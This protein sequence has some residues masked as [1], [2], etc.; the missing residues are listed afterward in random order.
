MVTAPSRVGRSPPANH[1]ITWSCLS[2]RAYPERLNLNCTYRTILTVKLR[3]RLRVEGNGRRSLYDLR[4]TR[5]PEEPAR[6]HRSGID[7]LGPSSLPRRV[8]NRTIRGNRPQPRTG[9]P[10]TRG[11]QSRSEEVMGPRPKDRRWLARGLLRLS[12]FGSPIRGPG[13]RRP[14]RATAGGVHG[15]RRG[16]R[17]SDAAA[18]SA[19]TAG[20]DP[21][22]RPQPLR[23]RWR[24]TGEDR[25]PVRMNRPSGRP[26]AN[27]FLRSEKVVMRTGSARKAGHEDRWFGCCRTQRGTSPN[28]PHLVRTPDRRSTRSL[29]RRTSSTNQSLTITD[30]GDPSERAP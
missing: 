23:D 10:A 6:R 8:V 18:M 26:L 1:L 21:H 17:R 30:A 12:C 20:D 25:Q 3:V 28:R 29:A 15:P 19:S 16:H 11:G 24:T 13:W 22:L 5:V 9:L 4:G 7:G 27:G 2:P 14:D